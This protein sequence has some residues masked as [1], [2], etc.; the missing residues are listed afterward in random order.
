MHRSTERTGW[1]PDTTATINV[2]EKGL[3]IHEDVLHLQEE[4]SR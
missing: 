1:H 4:D 3:Q 2:A